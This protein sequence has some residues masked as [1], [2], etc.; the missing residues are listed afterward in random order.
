MPIPLNFDNTVK[1]VEGSPITTVECN[2]MITTM[3]AAGFWFTDMKFIN[4]AN[5]LMLFVKMDAIYGYTQAQKINEV[6]YTQA[7]LDADKA[8]E[9][10]NGWWPTGIFIRPIGDEIDPTPFIHYQRLDELPT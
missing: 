8:A 7:A 10:I 6:D 4:T 5:A 1:L 3:N 9:I 2:A